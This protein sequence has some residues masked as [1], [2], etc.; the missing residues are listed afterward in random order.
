MNNNINN[1][2]SLNAKTGAFIKKHRI[3]KGLTG[4]LFGNLLFISQQQVSR[5]ETG[6]NVLSITMLNHCLNVLGLTWED[7]IKEVIYKNTIVENIDLTS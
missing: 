6:K 3:D 5:Y 1:V 2:I 4:V 7:Y